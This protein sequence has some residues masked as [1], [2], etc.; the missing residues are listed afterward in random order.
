[1]DPQEQFC[2]NM[3]CPARGKVSQN[4]IV[5]HSRKEARYKCKI[6]GKTFAA[7][8]GTPFYRLR[9]P[10]EMVIIVV[11]LIAHG[12][13]VQA[14]VAA[15]HL[16]ERTV[17]DW[18]ERSGKHSQQVHQHMVQQPRDLG[19]VQGDEV[20]V[21]TQG[22]VVWMAMAI[23]V[24]TRL[25][26]G[27]V[28]SEHRDEKLITAL[29][30]IVRSCALARPLLFCVDG[31]RS[32]VKVIQRVYRTPLPT[33]KRGRPRLISW[34]DIH[35]GQVIKRYE[36]KRVVDVIHRMAQGSLDT[37]LTLIENSNGGSQLN[38]A[39]I[40]RI[41][42]TF[43]SRLAVLARRSRALLR[44]PDTLEP[45][46]YL[47]GCIYN[48]CTYHKSL[49]LPGIIG[50]HKW[51][52]RTPAITAGLT[53][54]IWTVKELLLFRVPPLSWQPPKR[55]GRPSRATVALIARWCS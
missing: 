28:I 44:N 8:T 30:Q 33:G 55:P 1:M 38:T 52:P 31:L 51:I 32:Y 6:C 54:H 2:P 45:L 40:E 46:M 36:G 12:C 18:Q 43:R 4:N 48:F 50:G 25:W 10:M 41:N 53:D 23:M 39:F 21:K 35:I 7:T 37:A 34:P 17:M 20:R 49:R 3:A 9:H 11:T 29:I 13:P 14:I 15:F 22:R 24:S 5:I 27:G 19:H 16:D 42:A 47:M 26:L